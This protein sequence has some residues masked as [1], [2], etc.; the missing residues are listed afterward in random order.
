MT[1]RVPL[2]VLRGTV[3]YLGSFGDTCML[4]HGGSPRIWNN[5]T[6]SSEKYLCGEAMHGRHRNT[7]GI[8]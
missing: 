4:N 1:E 5:S 8:W 3:L 6:L 2:G 7:L